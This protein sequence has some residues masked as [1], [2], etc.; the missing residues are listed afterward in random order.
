MKPTNKKPNAFY[1]EKCNEVWR[2]QAAKMYILGSGSKT[3]V[4]IRANTVVRAI[5]NGKDV[6]IFYYKKEVIE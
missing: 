3:I 5:V 1:C 4:W 2:K 6:P